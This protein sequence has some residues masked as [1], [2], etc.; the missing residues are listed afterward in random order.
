VS[1]ILR[2]FLSNAIKFTEKGEVRVWST[3]NPDA[4]LITFHVRDTGIGIAEEDLG[5]IFEEFGQV[6]HPMQ[7]RVKGTG[8]G[9]P[10]SKRLA[11]LLG[12]AIKVQSAPGQG[13]VFSVTLPRIYRAAEIVEATEEEWAVDPSRVPVLV[14]DDDLADS[15][16]MQRLLSS[17]GYQPIVART[18]AAAK[19][20]LGHVQP[21]AVL[22]DVV[23]AGDESW[24][25]I[26]GLRQGETTG[27]IPIVVTSSTGEERKALHLGADA[28]LRKPIDHPRLLDTL[29]RL[30]GNRS[31][32]RVL[33]VDDEEVTR[34][35]VRQLLPR[36][37]YD[38]REAK[39]GTEGLAQLLNEPPDVVLLDLKM[40]EMTGFELLDRI[41]DEA[42]LDAVPAIVLTSAILTLD[43]R[44]RL[45]R[46]ARIMSKSDLSGS[47]LTGAITDAL[48]GSPSE[49]A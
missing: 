29:D 17:T 21:A 9:L 46:A 26:L 5:V 32:T 30:T 1:Q 16:A 13:S 3:V 24:R 43:E 28:Y 18:V 7:S 42:S 37:V 25:L 45:R 33:L 27:N 23:L 35:L 40:P 6:A 14:V 41:S 12:G 10:L 20:A 15:F 34:Y 11:E 4:D 38:V 2:N 44:Q 49:A 36:G 39:S 48:G 22:L 31:T 47:S 8:L 19:R